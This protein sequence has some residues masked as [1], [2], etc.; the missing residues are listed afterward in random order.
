MK[1]KPQ[2]SINLRANL[3]DVTARDYTF[4]PNA[5]HWW[6]LWDYVTDSFPQ[7]LR[8]LFKKSR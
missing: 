7:T 5:N 3:N 2:L 8:N 6:K 4:T 1:P